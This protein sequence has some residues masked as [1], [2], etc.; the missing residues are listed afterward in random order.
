VLGY[1]IE[2]DPIREAEDELIRTYSDVHSIPYEQ[3]FERLLAEGK[4]GQLR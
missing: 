2:V 3:A 1:P 4:I